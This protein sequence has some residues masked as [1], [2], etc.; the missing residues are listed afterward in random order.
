MKISIGADHAGFGLKQH[1][2]QKLE[3][4]G[5]E[6]TDRGTASTES[7]DYPDYAVPVSRDVAEGRAE[8]GVLVC[9]TGIG[10]SITANKVPGVR[11]A[12]VM[13]EDAARLTRLHN[14]ANVIALGA[15]YTSEPEA[16]RLVDIFLNTEFE[17]G[18]HTRRVG[19][20]AAAETGGAQ[21]K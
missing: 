4:M 17:G 9:S 2:K 6:V 15:R 12:L 5:Y 3:Q 21:T 13:N 18:R 7:T 19:K 14:D 1:I 16:D 10:M 8:R 20:I 11:A